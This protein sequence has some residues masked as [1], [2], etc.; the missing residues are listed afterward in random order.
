MRRAGLRPAL[1]AGLPSRSR[2]A[3]LAAP[4]PGVVVGG[5]GLFAA[6]AFR[7]NRIFGREWY[8]RDQLDERNISTQ[9]NPESDT[10]RRSYSEKRL[11]HFP[12]QAQGAGAPWR[13]LRASLA[14]PP[15]PSPSRFLFPCCG[16]LQRGREGAQGQQACRAQRISAWAQGAPMLHASP[17]ACHA[18]RCL[19]A[20]PQPHSPELEAHRA[21]HA[22]TL[23]PQERD[24]RWH[25]SHVDGEAGLAAAGC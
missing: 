13:L 14:L 6:G 15:P 18:L 22:T 20:F 12:E 17:A 4:A 7:R 5:G 11:G 2:R 19:T 23:L 8:S 9:K 16:S 10:G 1:V 3:G 25:W 24:A 21:S